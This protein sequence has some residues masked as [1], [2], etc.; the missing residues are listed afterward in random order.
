M[1]DEW[2]LRSRGVPEVLYVRMKEVGQPFEV[3]LAEQ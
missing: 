3:F 1:E 2:R